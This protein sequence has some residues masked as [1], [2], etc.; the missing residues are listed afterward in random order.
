M[1]NPQHGP[2]RKS[3]RSDT[4]NCVEVADLNDGTGVLVRDSK[5]KDGPRL[6]ISAPGWGA[7][8]AAATGGE[9]GRR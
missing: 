5:D 9:F 1:L 6:S 4:G 8:V 3:T 2:F 7:F